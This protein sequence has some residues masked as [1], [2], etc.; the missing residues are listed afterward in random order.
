MFSKETY[1]ERRKAL[2]NLVGNGL[3]VLLGNNNSPANYPNNC[4]TFRQDS[5]FL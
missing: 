5:T 2:K 4:Y 3:I 1:I